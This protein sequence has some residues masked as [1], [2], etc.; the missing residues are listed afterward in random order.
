M[1]YFECIIG[2][3]GSAEAIPLIV[4]C[5]DG[6]AGATI[7]ATDGIT[8]LTDVCPMVSPYQVTFKLPNDGTWTVSGLSESKTVAIT[9][10]EALLAEIP[11]GSTVT[12]TDDIKIWLNCADIWD[13]NYTTISEVLNDASTLQA[14]IASNNAADYMVR[15]TTWANSICA[16]S[17]AMSYIG[18]NDYCADTLLDDSTWLNAICNSANFESVLS[19]KVPTMTSATT[20]SGIVTGSNTQETYYPYNLFD[21]NDTTIWIGASNTANQ[22][23]KYRFATKMRPNKAVLRIGTYPSG[24]PIAPVIQGSN[25]NSNWTQLGTFETITSN[26]DHQLNFLNSTKYEYIEILFP[27]IIN[28]TNS[29]AYTFRSL[30]FYGRE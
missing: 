16:D 27:Q 6:F 1:A 25:D 23:V 18:L 4:T 15:S 28:V 19:S 21:G 22:W 2:N 29:W 8:T 5:A 11:E 10:Y 26:G 3:G 14:L 17:S 24:H 9:P 7:T 20:P 12:P 13:K 30:Q